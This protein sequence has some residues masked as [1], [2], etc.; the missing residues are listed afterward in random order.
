MKNLRL[1]LLL[2]MS[3]CFTCAYSQKVYTMHVEKNNGKIYDFPVDSIK[4]MTFT[5]KEEAPVEKPVA[6]GKATETSIEYSADGFESSDG[7]KYNYKLLYTVNVNVYDC[8][9]ISRFGYNI[10]TGSWYWDNPT[11][12]TTYTQSMTSLSNSSTISVTL[13]AFANMKDGT[14]YTGNTQTI[15]AT[16][17]GS[18]GGDNPVSNKFAEQTTARTFYSG[19]H[20]VFYSFESLAS[21]LN[22]HGILIYK[23]GSSYYWKDLNG[24]KHSAVANYN[25]TDLIYASDLQMGDSKN[26]Y[27]IKT[28]YVYVSFSFKPF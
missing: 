10:G 12:N 18:G 9:N 7:T 17:S 13:T 28:A 8:N 22:I 2:L 26:G 21:T 3:A 24:N 25:Y 15:S 4:S 14:K 1:L 11:E 20:S 23:E 6:L 27:Q 16:Y 19:G 5:A